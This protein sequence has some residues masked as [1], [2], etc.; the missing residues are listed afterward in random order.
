M[1][2]RK[3]KKSD[4]RRLARVLLITAILNLIVSMIGLIQIILALI[5]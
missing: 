5:N 4:E 2:K 3:Y 1:S